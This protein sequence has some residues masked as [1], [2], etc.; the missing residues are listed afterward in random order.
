MK[1]SVQ[2]NHSTSYQERIDVRVESR[3]EAL[4]SAHTLIKTTTT[5]IN[6]KG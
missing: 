1:E 3:V 6:A 5:M 4:S 2:T